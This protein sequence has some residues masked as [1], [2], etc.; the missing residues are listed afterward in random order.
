MENRIYDESNGL[1]YAK[2]GD[3]YL[4]ELAFAVFER[5]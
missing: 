1:W 5:A 2:K 3:Y 4:P